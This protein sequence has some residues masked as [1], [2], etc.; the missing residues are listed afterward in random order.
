MTRFSL[1][2]VVLPTEGDAMLVHGEETAVRDC[3]AVGIAREVGQHCRG[4][5]KR[6][7]GI[8]HPFVLSQRREPASEVVGIGERRVLAEELQARAAMERAKLLEEATWGRKASGL[9]VSR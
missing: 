2:P 7:L 4:T 8:H 9:L 1:G 5:S 6:A 3:H